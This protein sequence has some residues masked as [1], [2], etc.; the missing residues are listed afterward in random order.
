[1]Y[2]SL[3]QTATTQKKNINVMGLADRTDNNNLIKYAIRYV[4]A[5]SDTIQMA[6]CLRPVLDIRLASMM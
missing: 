5:S 1:M 3:G 2:S 4:R 6:I